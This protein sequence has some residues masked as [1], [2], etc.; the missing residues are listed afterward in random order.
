MTEA[1]ARPRRRWK[2]LRIAA[3]ITLLL[4]LAGLWYIT[5]DSFQQYVRRRLIAEVERITGGRAEIGGF[6]VIPLR[7]QVEVRDITVH[8]TEAAT[9]VPLAHADSLI[10]HLKVISFLRAEFGFHSVDLQHPVVHIAVAKDGTTNIPGTRLAEPVAPSVRVEQL[11]ALSIDHLAMRNGDLLWGD[12]RIP[13]DLTLQDASV[14]ADYSFLRGRYETYVA[15]G[16]VDTAIED[17]RPFSWMATIR[18]SLATTFAEVE[19]LEWN[20]GR[21]SV[22]VSG[23]VSDFR[24]PHLEGSYEARVNLSDAAAIARRNEIREGTAEF[25]GKGRWSLGDFSTSGSAVL[26]DVSWENEDFVIRKA[27]GSG[28]YSVDDQKIKLTKLQGKLFEGNISGDAQVDNWLRSIPIAVANKNK[29]EEFPEISA[30]HP[31]PKRG[32][33]PKPVGVQT[34]AVHLRLRDVSV[35]AAAAGLDTAAHPLGN[36]RPTGTAAGSLEITW[37]GEARNAEVAFDLSVNPPEKNGARELPLTA[38][39]LGKY[40]AANDVLELTQFHL[41]TPASRVQASGTMSPTSALRA[42]VSTSNLEEWRPLVT[43][44]GGP[45]NVP[46]R[47][48]GA[49]AFNGAVGGTFRAPT[50]VG[51]MVADD[52]EFTIP[53]TS[54]TAEK[55]VHWDSLAAGIQFS[56]REVTLRGGSLRRG[57]TSA[58]FDVTAGLEKGKFTDVSPIAGQINL[59]KIDIASTEALLGYEYPVS[60]MADVTLRIQGTRAAP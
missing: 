1:V 58:S 36:F 18:V 43:A 41:A 5:T 6:H 47:V 4:F 55:P 50:I 17:L 60:G 33:K 45:T 9:A 15:I 37:K 2:Y 26:R 11:F 39:A 57:D 30:V 23:R 28:D 27:G 52:F 38:K 48:D 3:G 14:Q 7:M 29:R 25:K 49:A 13:L 31:L 54:H 19:S 10:A 53:A 59:H 35:A 40:R 16:K 46:F 42:E 44:L 34:G 24:D 32:E 21:S 12:R 51:T 8:G 20:S 56:A 22:K